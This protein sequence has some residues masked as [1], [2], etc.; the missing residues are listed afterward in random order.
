MNLTNVAR[1]SL[2]EARKDY[3]KHLTRRGLRQW[4]EGEAVFAEA[5][6]LRPKTL[7]EA[8]AWVNRPGAAE[9]KEERAANL[10]AILAA[11]AHWLTERLLD[12]QARD[13]EAG[14]GFAERLYRARTGSSS[15]S[16]SSVPSDK[17]PRK[18]ET[19]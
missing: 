1:S 7:K 2:D 18:Q 4:D 9:P 14:G 3:I 19:P 16:V 10:G 5:R 6:N 17:P 8:A 15:R 11:Q 12:R 13:F